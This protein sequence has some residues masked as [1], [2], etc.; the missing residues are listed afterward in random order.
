MAITDAKATVEVNARLSPES[1]KEL[2]G[3]AEMVK[4]M[5]PLLTPVVRS[6]SK[7]A[8]FL[9]REEVDISVQYLRDNYPDDDVIQAYA[10]VIEQNLAIWEGMKRL[11]SGGIDLSNY[12]LRSW[13]V[14]Q[15]HET[16]DVARALIEFEAIN[17]KGGI[18]GR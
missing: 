5:K 16:G 14:N 15:N 18:G 9:P 3:L 10:Q 13:R 6:P 1:R 17:S 11:M 12:T 2:E 7:P 4:T 8:H